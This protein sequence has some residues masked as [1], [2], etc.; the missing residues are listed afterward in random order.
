MSTNIDQMLKL[1][2]IMLLNVYV[3][4]KYV[5]EQWKHVYDCV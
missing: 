4:H 3:Y 1:W 5:C 2:L